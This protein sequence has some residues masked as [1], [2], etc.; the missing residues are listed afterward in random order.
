MN[1]TLSVLLLVALGAVVGGWLARRYPFDKPPR[2]FYAIAAVVGGS[3]WAGIQASRDSSLMYVG[4]AVAVI[5]GSAVA[6]AR[7]RRWPA[8]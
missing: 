2:A 1:P 7:L 6:I 3:I 4:L 5:L 8:E